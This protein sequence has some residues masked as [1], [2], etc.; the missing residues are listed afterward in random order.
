MKLGVH[1]LLLI[2]LSLFIG[3]S[4]AVQIGQHGVGQALI[5]P[6][7]TV[8]NDLNTLYSIVNTTD[9]P[10]AVRLRFLEGEI[11]RDVLSFNV[12][13]SPFDVWTGALVPVVSTIQG[14]V[15]EP[16]VSHITNDTSCVPFLSLPSQELLPFLIDEDAPNNSMNRAR[17]GYIEVIEMGVL[18]GNAAQA[19]DHGSVGVPIDC[20]LLENDWVDN[21]WDLDTVEDPTGGLLGSISLINVANGTNFSYDAIALENFWDQAGLHTSPGG[22][23]PNLSS[24]SNESRVLLASGELAV[25]EWATGF[26]A[27]SALLMQAEIYNEYDYLSFLNGKSDW[28]VS[29][30]TKIYHTD[31]DGSPIAPFNNNW[32]GNE[33]CD[34]FTITVWD[35]EE[36]GNMIN[37]DCGVT[38]PPIDTR[39]Q[40][41]Y[42]SN[43]LEFIAPDVTQEATSRVL[44][45]DNFLSFNTSNNQFTENGW[46]SLHFLS[47]NSFDDTMMIPVTGV[48]YKGLPLTGFMV[49]QYTNAGAAE[50]LLAQ[51]GGLFKHKGLVDAGDF[52]IDLVFRNAFD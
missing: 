24:A 8:N 45:S 19:I 22:P 25:S 13:L 3:R 5:F 33:A 43:V 14:H 51:Y 7:Y 38:C 39:P 16:S 6:Y 30:P 32:D 20:N 36:M 11:G 1:L 18:T 10:K 23:L 47:A 2:A 42:S 49:Q 35:R 4:S 44:G 21:Q 26:E 17:E 37:G 15:G 12:Y 50:G 34:G 31:V 52:G 41:C 9:Q 27:V 48:G 40:L 46:A 28:V 29:F